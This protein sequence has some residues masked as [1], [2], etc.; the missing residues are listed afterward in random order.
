M[1][2]CFFLA[3]LFVANLAAA[4]DIGK[5][6]I[7]DY[8]GLEKSVLSRV[9]N[10]DRLMD[11]F[12]PVNR[13]N[14]IVVDVYYYYCVNPKDHNTKCSNLELSAPNN[15]ESWENVTEMYKFRWSIS[16]VNTFIHPDL[17]NRMSLYT[18]YIN[19][20]KARVVIDR[21]S[22]DTSFSDDH[23]RKLVS[24]DMNDHSTSLYAT[25]TRGNNGSENLDH[26]CRDPPAYLTLL[27]RFTANGVSD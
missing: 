8:F 11:A 4:G 14:T 6:P 13:Q 2:Q 20:T 18:F 7:S 5:K 9:S 24:K 25:P 26:V 21:L 3:L 19:P 22:G 16:F 12:F 27:N 10:I 23:G 1:A 17:L 15:A